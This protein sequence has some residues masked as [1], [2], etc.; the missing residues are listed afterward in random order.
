MRL[1]SMSSTLPSASRRSLIIRFTLCGLYFPAMADTTIPD[2]VLGALFDTLEA[3]NRR[4]AAQYP[5]E[6][7]RRQPVHTLYGGAHLF[8]A[9]TVPK[10]GAIALRTL[11]EYAP[12]PGALAEAI[13]C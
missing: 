3:G 4:I 1:V 10:L 8:T 12:T 7:A 11:E 6:P 13:G 2:Q 9:G 5:G